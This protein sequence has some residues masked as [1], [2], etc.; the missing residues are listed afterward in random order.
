MVETEKKTDRRLASVQGRTKTGWE[1]SD[2][3]DIHHQIKR[4]IFLGQKNTEI[5]RIL[6]CTKEQVSSVRNSPVIQDELKKM[7]ADADKDAVDVKAAVKKLAPKALRVMEQILDDE[8]VL[9]NVR[10]NAAK[11]ALDR[12]GHAAPQQINHLHGHFTADDILEMKNRA[13]QLAANSGTIETDDVIDVE[14]VD[15]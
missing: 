10:F 12:G 2:I 15:V 5:A 11:D 7:Q 8:N 14:A 9:A 4:R 6:G 13:K 3:W 1:V